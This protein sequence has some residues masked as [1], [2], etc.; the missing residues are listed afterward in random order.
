MKIDKLYS[1]VYT[2]EGNTCLLSSAGLGRLGRLAGAVG[3]ENGHLHSEVVL[4]RGHS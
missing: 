1:Q 4:W 3:A 2:I